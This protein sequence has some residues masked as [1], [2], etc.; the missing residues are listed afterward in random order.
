MLMHPQ[1]LLYGNSLQFPHSYTQNVPY[2]DTQGKV[3]VRVNTLMLQSFALPPKMRVVM[4][5]QIVED[6][7]DT[8]WNK[9]DLRVVEDV[10]AASAIVHSALGNTQTPRDMKETVQKWVTA[11]P[12]IHVTLLHT[13]EENGL[14]ISHWK[15]E[16]THQK[17]LNG[18][19]A[20]GNPVSYNGVSM[21]RFENGKVVEY[22]AY[23]DTWVLTRQMIDRG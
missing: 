9:K 8:V 21:Y 12:D 6:Y 10:F 22:W 23:L 13:L 11:I 3:V 20:R 4:S 19:P 15:A 17:E 18:I 7:M 5:K 14:V 16:G 1:I 2:P